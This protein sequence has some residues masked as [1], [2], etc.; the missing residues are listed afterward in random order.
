MFG[1]FSK[2]LAFAVLISV[3]VPISAAAQGDEPF[4]MKLESILHR[5]K[6]YRYS[7]VSIYKMKD[8]RD[9]RRAIQSKEQQKAVTS[10][11]AD[12]SCV[13]NA[14]RTVA[15]LIE[16]GVAQQLTKAAV[17]RN[18]ISRGIAIPEEFDCIYDVF[19]SRRRGAVQQIRSVYVVTTRMTKDQI[20][21]NTIIAMIVSLE[22]EEDMRKNID[23]AG[24]DRIYTNPEL[25]VFDLDS[26]D[27]SAEN[28]HQLLI[29]TFRQNNVINKTLEA[30]GIGTLARFAPKLHGVSE[31]LITNEADISSI[32][33]QSFMRISDGQSQDYFLK[34][35][36]MIV[37]PDLISWRRY[38]IYSVTYEDGFV[39]TLSSITNKNLP[40]FGLELRYGLDDINYPSLWSERMTA[41]AVWQSVKLGLILPTAGWAEI[42]KTVYDQTRK[43]THAGV[44][45]A[46]QFDFPIKVIPE[47]GVFS[48]GFNYVFGDAKQADYKN[49]IVDDN[50]YV[51]DEINNPYLHND[52]LIRF[53]A[54]MHYTF[55]VSI[56]NDYHLRFGI[57][58]TVYTAEKWYNQKYFNEDNEP[59]HRY[60][61]AKDETVGGVSGRI[62]FMAKNISTPFG[63]SIQYFDEA[64]YAN[65]WFQIPIIENTLALR[66]DAKGGFVAFRNEPRAWENQSV[67]MLMPRF[68]INF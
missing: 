25:L 54:R 35:N 57:G 10:S 6:N 17:Q 4:R 42:T 33:I 37:S 26:K 49:R 36:E 18:L 64:A 62:D 5:F 66:F 51:Y 38:G 12:E 50:T 39:D 46:G 7:S 27:Y 61:K 23:R 11:N 3:V 21:P 67:F 68:V 31:S 59:N 13:N 44:G 32:D 41:Y 22:D 58:G 30:Q 1:K 45:V 8:V 2:L 43:L 24:P 40:K 48:L 28:M 15:S 53:N 20:E 19:E 55:G 60:V 52:Y 47:S 56:D 9:V 63:A 16:T 14:D 29:N 34:D 65:I